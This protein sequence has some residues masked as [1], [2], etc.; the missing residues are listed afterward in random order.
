MRQEL[1]KINK[2]R[3]TFNGLFKRYGTKYNWHGFPETTILLVDIKDNSDKIITDH[4]WFKQ[5]KGFIAISPLTEG[6]LI[7]FEARVKDYIKGYHG[8]KAEE[9]GEEN[10]ELD[11]KLNFPT[12]I[13]K[14]KK[15]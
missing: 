11:Y 8:R 4:I 5:T 2:L 10:Y 3:K 6:D 13:R 1:K 9:Y 14:I 12:K 7:E 15:E